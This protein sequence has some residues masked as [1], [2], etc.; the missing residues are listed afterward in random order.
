MMV[1]SWKP[2]Q[3]VDKCDFYV[4]TIVRVFIIP[5]IKHYTLK[6]E[7]AVLICCSFAQQWIYYCTHLLLNMLNI[8]TEKTDKKI[9]TITNN[10]VET[11][12]PLFTLLCLQ[13]KMECVKCVFLINVCDHIYIHITFGTFSYFLPSFSSQL[14]TLVWRLMNLA[15]LNWPRS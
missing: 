12:E 11:L 5:Y 9:T 15:I 7:Y 6:S 13:Y 8:G 14:K 3:D 4:N 1:F 10:W 2:L